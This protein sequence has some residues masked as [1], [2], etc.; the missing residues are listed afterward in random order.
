MAFSFV[1]ASFGVKVLQVLRRAPLGVPGVATALDPSR[2]CTKD[3][4]Q[5]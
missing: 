2:I 1:L 4:A 3:F 5:S